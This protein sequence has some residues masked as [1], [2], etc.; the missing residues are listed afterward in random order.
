VDIAAAK[1]L[2]SLLE[3]RLE[4]EGLKLNVSA[5]P[6]SNLALAGGLGALGIDIGSLEMSCD[7]LKRFG[8]LGWRIEEVDGLRLL[9]CKG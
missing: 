9:G 8:G 2:G 7:D 5:R 3:R 1:L 6:D 4:S